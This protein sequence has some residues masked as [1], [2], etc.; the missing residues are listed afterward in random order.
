MS[1]TPDEARLQATRG[2]VASIY[3][4]MPIWVIN[5][6]TFAVGAASLVLVLLYNYQDNMLYMPSGGGQINLSPQ[7]NPEGWRN[8]LDHP[9]RTPYED[10]L[11]E[12]ADGIKISTWLMLHKESSKCP[13]LIY[14]HGNAGN[15]GHRLE[16]SIKMLRLSGLNVLTVDYRGYGDSSG[17]PTEKGLNLDADAVL[18]Y[19]LNH[20]KL[21][22]S[23]LI[24]FGRS[25]GG[26]V[27]VSLAERRPDRI[28][29][30]VVENTFLSIAA[31]VDALMPGIAFAKN[32]VLRIGW[33]SH[34]KIQRLKCPIM[35]I[36]GENDSLVPPAHM[37]KLHEV[38]KKSVFKEFVSVK[39]GTHN[40][41]F[42]IMGRA[43]YA[44][45]KEFVYRDDIM[46]GLQCTSEKEMQIAEEGEEDQQGPAMGAIPTMNANFGVDTKK[47][48]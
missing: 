30:V 46:K 11:V 24:A 34:D 6:T 19:A 12:T 8:P 36:S 16:N 18:D 41:S 40:E 48:N 22:G 21:K 26:A 35:F 1:A 20:P 43:Y 32:L 33:D 2:V 7:E 9:S 4:S 31:M 17:A 10:K 42:V 5:L 37:H 28:A 44:K 45:L 38:A 27:A 15:M 14:F 23:P 47:T 25:L 39:G 3:N 13:T 29:A